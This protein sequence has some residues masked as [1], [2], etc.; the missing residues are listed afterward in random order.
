MTEIKKVGYKFLGFKNYGESIEIQQRLQD[1]L[2]NEQAV[3]DGF[4]LIL[5]HEPIITVGK[6]SDYSNLLVNREKLD[7]LG[8][9]FYHSDRGGDITCHEPGQIVVYP[10]FNLR[11]FNLK[12]KDYVFL[13]ERVVIRFLKD[14]DVR[15][16]RIKGKPGVWVGGNKIASVGISIKRHCTKH[17]IAVNVNNSL[18]YFELINPCG[19]QNLGITSLKKV[20]NYEPSLHECNN[21]ILEHFSAVFNVGVE[22]VDIND[23]LSFGSSQISSSA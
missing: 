14:F 6:Y 13:L 17:G 1:L 10:I 8:V 4:L 5:Y 3:F 18:K 7:R 16:D 23:F 11:K 9:K 2:I 19:F 20:L 12:V 21:R 15:S 22:E